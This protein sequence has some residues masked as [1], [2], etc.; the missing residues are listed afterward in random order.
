MVLPD[1]RRWM[2]GKL[3]NGK[4]TRT[5]IYGTNNKQ[6]VI[7]YHEDRDLSQLDDSG[8][9]PHPHTSRRYYENPKHVSC[10]DNKKYSRS[11]YQGC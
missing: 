11:I 5:S 8:V 4:L 7:D 3:A 9:G 1:E 6:S 10:K 2:K